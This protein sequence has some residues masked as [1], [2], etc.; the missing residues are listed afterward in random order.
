MESVLNPTTTEEIKVQNLL[1]EI[2]TTYFSSEPLQHQFYRQYFNAIDCHDR[3]WYK[4]PY[5]YQVKSN[6]KTVYL[7][8]ILKVGLI[9]TW[10]L[11]NELVRIDLKDYLIDIAKYLLKLAEKHK[12]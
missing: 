2:D 9:N 11:H 1:K 6:W 3:Y 4:L 12:E 7:F 10:V 8:C 5:N